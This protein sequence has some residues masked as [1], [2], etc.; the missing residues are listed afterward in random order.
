MLTVGLTPTPYNMF[1]IDCEE[2]YLESYYHGFHEYESE[3]M[4]VPDY[5]SLKDRDYDS[6][7]WPSEWDWEPEWFDPGW[8]WGSEDIW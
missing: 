2:D 5:E 1:D 4:E 3:P 8:G 6:P 7:D